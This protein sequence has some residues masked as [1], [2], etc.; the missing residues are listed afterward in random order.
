MKDFYI[1]KICYV[2][3]DAIRTSVFIITEYREPLVKFKYEYLC[4]NFK[5]YY[6]IFMRVEQ[7]VFTD[8][9]K[10]RTGIVSEMH[11]MHVFINYDILFQSKATNLSMY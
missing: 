1:A 5:Y 9:R 4:M 10:R 8:M 7:H 2:S 11:V 3:L 6:S